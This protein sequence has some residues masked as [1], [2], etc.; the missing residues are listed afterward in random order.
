MLL[1]VSCCA[2]GNHQ[3]TDLK[4]DDFTGACR[5][6]AAEQLFKSYKVVYFPELVL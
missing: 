1:Q 6:V 4:I 2:V 5:F 3:A